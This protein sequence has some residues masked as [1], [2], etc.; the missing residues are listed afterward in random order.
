MLFTFYLPAQ[1]GFLLFT[2][3]SA[4]GSFLNVVIDRLETNEPILADRSHCDSCKHILRWYDLIPII[5]FIFLR[6]KCRYCGR[7]L[8]LQYPLVEFV[9]GVLFVLVWVNIANGR[10]LFA[11]PHEWGVFLLLTSYFSLLISAMLVIFVYDLKHKIIPDQI[12]LPAVII[13]FL[14]RIFEFLKIG[15]PAGGLELGALNLGFP[16]PF[17]QVLLNPLLSATAAGLFFL[18]L[19]LVTK[20]RGMGMGDVKLVFLM[21]LILGWPGI[22]IALYLSF[23]TGALVGLFLIAISKKRFGQEIPFGPFL[24]ASTIITLLY[25]DILLDLFQTFVPIL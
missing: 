3:G 17:A 8:R 20:G 4:V 1:A 10:E 16:R 9:T 25:G 15:P 22:L 13:T 14:F 19:I 7:P 5:S 21:G 12:V 6:G 2:F 24:S 11:N 18:T 23:I